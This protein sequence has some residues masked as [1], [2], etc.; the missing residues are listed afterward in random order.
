M[1]ANMVTSLFDKERIQT[2]DPKA[3]EARRQAERLITRAK[4]GYTAYVEH[5]TLKDAGKEAESKQMQAEALAHWR[6]ASRIVRKKSVLKKLFDTIAPKY[7]DRDGGYTR[8]LKLG[9]RLGDNARTVLLEL[10]GTEVTD[11]SGAK[12]GKKEAGKKDASSGEKT[13]AKGK[14]TAKA[15]EKKSTKKVTKKTAPAEKTAKD[16]KKKKEVKPKEAKSKEA[17]EEKNRS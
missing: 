6:V 14:K 16:V 5:Q 3:K 17:S 4:K 11:E 9:H 10:V 13:E 2:T 15:K 12:K 8:I 1:L 7:L